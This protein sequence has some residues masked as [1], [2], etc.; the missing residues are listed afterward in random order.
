MYT[1][2]S[3]ILQYTI[4]LALEKL[5]SSL[6]S[7]KLESLLTLVS[8]LLLHINDFSLQSTGLIRFGIGAVKPFLEQL[9]DTLRQEVWPE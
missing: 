5:S 1:V 2:A 7:A 9:W 6:S 4:P 3:P 8:L